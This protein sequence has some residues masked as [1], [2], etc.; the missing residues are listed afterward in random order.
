MKKMQ[1]ILILWLLSGLFSIRSQAD[2]F[3]E[4]PSKAYLFQSNNVQ[5]F[6]VNLVTGSFQLL[7][8]YVGIDGNINGVGFNFIDR[9]IY[10]FN[11][12]TYKVVRIGGD[13]QASVLAVT[14][15]PENTT[16][17]VGDVAENYYYLYRKN[18]GFFRVNLDEN[19]ADYLQ[20]IE[21]DTA[22]ISLNLTDFAIH[23]GDNM[24][25]AVDNKSG[26]LY[27][28]SLETGESTELGFT[29]ET[30]TFGAG[31]FDVNGYYYI[32]RNSDGKIFRI[33]I[34]DVDNPVAQAVLFAQGPFSNQND[35]ARC[36]NAPISVDNID[37]GDAP[38]SY[39]TLL[40][41]NGARHELSDNL[42]LGFAKPDGESDGLPFAVNDDG[43]NL[44]DEDAIGFLTPVEIGLDSLVQIT[45][46]G[47]GYLTAWFDWNGNG[48]FDDSSEKS[49]KD[50]ALTSGT[51]LLSLRVPSD[52]VAGS[53]WARFRYSSVQGLTPLGGAPDGEVEDYSVSVTQP[54]ISYRYYPSENGWVALAFEDLWPSIGDYDMNDVVLHYRIVELV[55]DEKIIRTD[56]YGQLIA[57]GAIYHNGFAV[58]LEGVPRSAVDRNRLRTLFN[59]QVVNLNVLESGQTEAVIK[60]TDDLWQ[61][62][63]SECRFY[64][65]DASCTEEVEF[66][67]EMSVNFAQ[68]IL[69]ND[70]PAAP[71]N[72]FIFATPYWGRDEFFDEPPGRGLEIHLADKPLTDLADVSLLGQGDDTSELNTNRLFKTVNNMPW[73]LEIGTEW[74]HPKERV[75][76]L[77]AY[78]EFQSWVESGGEIN[79]DWYSPE[80]S[81]PEK[82]YQ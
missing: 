17:F 9:Y 11:T 18:I 6:G 3:T 45:V 52:A 34:S 28:I 70:M 20:A 53:T 23:P 35:G 41:D 43:S 5:V 15:L 49:F 40:A 69:L 76:I 55:R 21:I 78:P 63:D 30:G 44:D 65:T 25:Y 48:V 80:K 77:E 47:S 36:A 73:A 74:L 4:C 56:I 1:F 27:R 62:V 13:F 46:E 26:N 22:D 37:W 33:D 79:A 64:R 81:N 50:H 38:P 61:Q 7:E 16:F 29:G 31:Y 32:S 10:G 39:G 59:S 67:F 68:G 14:G 60:V 71:Y 42:Y 66:S 51:H 19:R 24:L 75:D 82:V 54:D 8:D 72:P 58:H 12:S 57:M 2:P